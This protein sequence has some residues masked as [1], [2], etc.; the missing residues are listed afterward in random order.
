LANTQVSHPE[1]RNDAIIAPDF[2]QLQIND[3]IL[4]SRIDLL[5]DDTYSTAH[6]LGDDQYL[7]IAQA[8]HAKLSTNNKRYCTKN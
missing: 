7:Q 2:D 5:F 6:P 4:I 1:H 8:D 3:Y